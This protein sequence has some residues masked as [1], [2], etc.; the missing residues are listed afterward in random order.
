MPFN[1]ANRRVVPLKH[2]PPD[3]VFTENVNTAINAH[4]AKTDPHPIYLTQAEG[5]ALYTLP[6]TTL[7]SKIV[8]PTTFVVAAGRQL[9]VADMLEIEDGATL[10]I[11]DGGLVA[12]I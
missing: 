8:A 2:L 10:S 6:Q 5:D 1:I 12:L 4:E 11:E 7:P 9:I 3:T